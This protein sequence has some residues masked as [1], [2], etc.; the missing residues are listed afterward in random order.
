M[1]QH[2][3]YGFWGLAMGVVLSLTG[4]S[5]FAEVH[6]MFTFADFRLY[7]VF[8]GAVALSGVGFAVFKSIR[9][10]G[11]KS[12]HSGTIPGSIMFGVGWA[13]TGA[14]PSVALVQLGEGQ[15]A[16]AFTLLGIYLGVLFYRTLSAGSLKLDTGVCGES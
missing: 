15:F 10:A 16:S 8:F 13:I 6:K 2:M 7:F 1:K 12:Y 5:N 11:K 4:F 9:N 14:C 3:L